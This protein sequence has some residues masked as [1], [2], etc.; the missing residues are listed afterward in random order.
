MKT[1]LR[2]LRYLSGSC[3]HYGIVEP[4]NNY[5]YIVGLRCLKGSRHDGPHDYGPGWRA[6]DWSPR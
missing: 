1:L 3:S 6:V 2:I 4:T 5:P